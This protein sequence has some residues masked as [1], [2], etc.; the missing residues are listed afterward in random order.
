M[1][2]GTDRQVM[3][4]APQ[5]VGDAILSLPLIAKLA[6]EYTAVDVLATPAVAAV[7]ACT[8]SVRTVM[9]EKFA[10]GKLQ[11]GLRRTVAQKIRNNYQSAV[12]LPNS[13]KSALIPWLAGIPVRR[14]L[15][16]EHRYVV[17]NDRR[18]PPPTSDQHRPSML[19]QY[20][21]LADQTPSANTIDGMHAHRPRMVIPS[22]QRRAPQPGLMILC[23]G[24]EYGPAKQWPAAHFAQ[25]AVAWLSKNQHHQVAIIGGP[26]DATIAAAI[27]SLIAQQVVSASLT[28]SVSHRVLQLSGKTELIE[29]F[30]WLAS[31]DLVVSNDS[32]L[33][34]A[35]AAL[36]I[37]V[38]AIFGSTDPHHTPPHSEKATILSLGLSCSP[39]FER[40]CPLGTTACL[41]DLPAERVIHFLP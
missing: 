2:T 9:I 13:F 37:P 25:V 40:V 4:I 23:P 32:G 26:K 27:E 33:M 14:G 5:W 24:A 18:L 21:L 12:V 39:C 31:A 29:A 34:H 3:V 16:G 8:P 38:I 7:Y 28:V 11:W 22:T 17:L 1:S 19:A 30:A 41:K 6:T 10:H 36:D 15:L 35:A 20:L